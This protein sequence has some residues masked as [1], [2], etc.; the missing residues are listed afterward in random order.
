M[1][2]EKEYNPSLEFDAFTA[3]VEDGGIRSSS[4]VAMIV[5][6]IVSSLE[7]KITAK[8]I[9]DALVDGKLANYFEVTNAVS[10][11]I[12]NGNLIE[13]EN[14]I[15]TATPKCKFA[16]EIVENDLPLSVREKSVE[17]VKK[18][19]ALEVN[20]KENKVSIAAENNGYKVT[21]HVSDVDSDFMTLSLYV[22][23]EA[24]AEVI[25]NKFLINPAKVY[26]NLI[27]SIFDNEE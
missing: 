4:T 16:I 15:L 17:L 27:E 9:V 14:G 23:T 6:Y 18:L 13:D 11:M 24:Q 1:D 22:P 25:K 5:C 10:K 3:G 26:E 12:K 8:I 20:K 19:A 7:E 21:L 2:K